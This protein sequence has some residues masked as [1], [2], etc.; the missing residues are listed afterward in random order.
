M[1]RDMLLEI[2]VAMVRD[3][4]FLKEYTVH[5]SDSGMRIVPENKEISFEAS[6]SYNSVLSVYEIRIRD[7]NDHRDKL[8]WSV[9]DS[10][11]EYG[12]NDREMARFVR[13]LDLSLFNFARRVA[14]F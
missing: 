9:S 8:E 5:L 6:V 13:W 2:M 1:N 4:N 10:E 14:R 12:L 7:I 3:R 11:V